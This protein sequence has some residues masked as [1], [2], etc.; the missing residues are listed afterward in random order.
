MSL[1]VLFQS[2]AT[3]NYVGTAGFTST[4]TLSAA[5]TVAVSG[6]A[7]FTSTG[8]LSTPTTLTQPGAGVNGAAV[9]TSNAT[10]PR[11]WDAIQRTGTGTTS[12]YDTA[13]TIHG[14]T[15]STK[16]HL[17]AVSST[18]HEAWKA[19]IPA[20][21]TDRAFARVY[22][23]MT[24]YPTA[25]TRMIALF[26][27][28]TVVAAQLQMNPAGTIRILNAAGSILATTVGVVPLSSWTRLELDITSI[29]G[30]TGTVAARM[31]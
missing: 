10:G 1:L 21:T 17:A 19:S 9:T 30:S 28:S 31:Y 27:G 3:G 24:A 18:A 8:T 7:A 11:Q 16:H 2:A 14:N 13:Q 23:Y 6:A 15:T 25:I 29:S 26:S 12:A 4:G 5:G 22:V 20:A